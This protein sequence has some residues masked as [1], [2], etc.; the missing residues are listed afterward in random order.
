MIEVPF[1][2]PKKKNEKL[3]RKFDVLMI[4]FVRSKLQRS[5]DSKKKKKNQITCEKKFLKQNAIQI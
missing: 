1:L 3:V 5:H 4:D 2:T